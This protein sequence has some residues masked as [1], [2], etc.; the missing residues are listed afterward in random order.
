MR[1]RLVL[2]QW[3]CIIFLLGWDL[4]NIHYA[5]RPS[6]VTV[7]KKAIMA[8]FVAQISQLTLTDEELSEKTTRFGQALNGALN[9]YAN[10]YQVIILDESTVLAGSRDVTPNILSLIATTMRGLK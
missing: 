7:D 1:Q 6:I 3:L 5:L 9:D 2:I 8:R 4:M 10:A